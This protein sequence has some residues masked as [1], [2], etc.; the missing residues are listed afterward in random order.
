MDTNNI[1]NVVEV[2]SRYRIYITSY[3]CILKISDISKYEK[4]MVVNIK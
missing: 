1:Y 2:L 4:R 3:F